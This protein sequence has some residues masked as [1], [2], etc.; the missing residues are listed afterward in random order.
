M[1]LFL[2]GKWLENAF[3]VLYPNPSMKKRNVMTDFILSKDRG[4]NLSRRLSEKL[5]WFGHAHDI[6]GS[7]ECVT[8]N[9]W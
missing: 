2:G 1:F 3:N 9:M 5:F 7:E 8:V 4:M 6:L